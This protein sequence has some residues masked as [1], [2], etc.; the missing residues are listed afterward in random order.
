MVVDGNE[1]E[2]VILRCGRCTERLDCGE[3]IMLDADGDLC[4]TKCDASYRADERAEWESS[5]GDISHDY[6]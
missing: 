6:D 3:A 1:V 4:H 2:V 5:H